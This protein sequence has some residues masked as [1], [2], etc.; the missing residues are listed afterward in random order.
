MELVMAVPSTMAQC[1]QKSA[2][3]AYSDSTVMPIAPRHSASS[4]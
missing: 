4:A 2:P 3:A 1:A